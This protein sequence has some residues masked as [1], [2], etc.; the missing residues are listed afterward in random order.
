MQEIKFESPNVE[1]YK[2]NL[3]NWAQEINWDV[4]SIENKLEFSKMDSVWVDEVFSEQ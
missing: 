2:T 3:R 1:E 4:R